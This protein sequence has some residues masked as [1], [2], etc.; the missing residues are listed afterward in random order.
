[1]DSKDERRASR[2]GYG[3]ERRLGS[4]LLESTYSERT[5]EESSCTQKKEKHRR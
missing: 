4:C 1:M 5:G 2:Q 3:Q